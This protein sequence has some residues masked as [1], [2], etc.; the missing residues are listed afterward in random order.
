MSAQHKA[1]P[2]RVLIVTESFLPQV[3]GVTASVC[4]VLEHLHDQGHTAAVIAPTGPD[5]Y[6]GSPVHTVPTTAVP[7]YT[8]FRAGWTTRRTIE[9]LIRR[10]RPD[11]VHLA[12]P[13]LL[14][15]TA[16]R[17]AQQ[18]GVPTVAVY[19]TDVVGFAKRYRLNTA[20]SAVERRVQRLHRRATRTLAPSRASMDQLVEL[21]IP[22]VHSWERGIDLDRFTP[23]NR[24]RPLPG[25]DVGR[26]GAGVEDRVVV[27]YVGRLAREKD[28]ADLRVIDGLD[29]VQLV[30][31][32]DGPLRAE[33][34]QQLPGARFLGE[35]HGD[36]LARL[37][38][39]LDIFVHTGAEETF[40]QAAQEALASGVP[41][42]GPASGGLLDRVDHGVNGLLYTAHDLAA[43]HSAVA[44]LAA[45]PQKR[46]RMALRARA[47][48]T[49]RSWS[50]LG[51]QLIAHYRGAIGL[52][53]SVPA[54]ESVLRVSPSPVSLAR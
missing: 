40:C 43:L 50:V 54:P 46:G 47:G 8:D 48:V 44:E 33:L 34:R 23:T 21:R 9:T 45:D 17:A 39:S 3:N 20:V 27:G 53:T 29:G 5:S 38:A 30:L 31:I 10:F 24:T 51:D 35:K 26:A 52:R 14:G 1:S 4:R 18:L 22:R 12:S 36:E 42:I 6:A 11:V 32:G 7:G 49:G 15:S 25:L 2:L 13:F 41:V 19:Q 16:A 28:L 37:M